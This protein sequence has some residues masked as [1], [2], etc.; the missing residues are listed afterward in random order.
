MKS[1]QL[2]MYTEKI[3]VFFRSKKFITEKRCVDKKKNFLILNL[4]VHKVTTE[5]ERDNDGN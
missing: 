4:A 2:R 3:T 1:D 5:P